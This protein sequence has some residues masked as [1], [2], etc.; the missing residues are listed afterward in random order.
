MNFLRGPDRLSDFQRNQF[1]DRKISER[2][3]EHERSHRRRDGAERD[4]TEDVE[5]FDLLAQQVE[6]IHHGA[7][8]S[9]RGFLE[10]SSRTRSIRAER[11][12][13]IKTR[14]PGAAL[15]SSN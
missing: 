12:P 8:S 2:Q 11:L 10:N 13:L 1:A 7:T 15:F 14:S 6:V 5:A 3:R 9:G 4:V